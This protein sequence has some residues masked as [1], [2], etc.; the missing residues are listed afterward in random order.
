[1]VDQLRHL[2]HR[3]LG[4]RRSLWLLLAALLSSWNAY[5]L[6]LADLYP[7]FQVLN[8]FL[9]FGCVIALEDRLPELWPR[10]SRSV[11]TSTAYMRGK[12]S[13]SG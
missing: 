12:T 10:P 6:W 3:H 8:L 1:M 4:N 2:L 7:S 9:W 11:S 13:M 5:V